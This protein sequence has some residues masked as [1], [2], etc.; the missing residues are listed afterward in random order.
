[1]GVGPS[2][3]SSC[4]TERASPKSAIFTWHS[5]FSSRLLGFTSRCSSSA[6]VHELERLEQLV[7]DVLLVD[8]LQDVGANHRV[9]VRLHVLEDEIDVPVV[10]R[11]QHVQ[12]PNDVFVVVHLLQEHDLAERALRRG[13]ERRRRRKRQEATRGRHREPSANASRGVPARPSRS[14]TRRRS[15]SARRCP[16]FSYRRLSRR[17]RTPARSEEEVSTIS[18]SAMRDT[19]AEGKRLERCLPLSPT[20]AGSHTSAARACLFLRS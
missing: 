10:L 5:L 14:E 12:K 13:N 8:L 18:T 15:S 1:M 19:G 3:S 7:H 11:L 2:S 17:C 4:A 6:G 9:Q 20:S 16:A